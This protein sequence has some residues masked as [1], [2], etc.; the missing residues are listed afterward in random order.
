MIFQ[1]LLEAIPCLQPWLY[2]ELQYLH[3]PRRWILPTEVQRLLSSSSKPAGAAS[4]PSNVARHIPPFL[5][6]GPHP[7]ALTRESF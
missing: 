6:F 5:L 2:L 4:V 7:S 3:L 1:G